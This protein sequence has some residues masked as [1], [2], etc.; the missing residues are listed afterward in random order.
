MS[1]SDAGESELRGGGGESATPL[2]RTARATTDRALQ[3]ERFETFQQGN[4]RGDDNAIGQGGLLSAIRQQETHKALIFGTDRLRQEEEAAHCR[5]EVQIQN[6]SSP[7]FTSC[8]FLTLSKN[9]NLNKAERKLKNLVEPQ[10]AEIG[11]Y[12]SEVSQQAS[13]CHHPLEAASDDPIPKT[14]S[15]PTKKKED[16]IPVI[17]S[18]LGTTR[19]F[20]VNHNFSHGDFGSHGCNG[21]HRIPCGTQPRRN[22]SG[23]VHLENDL[24]NFINLENHKAVKEP[25]SPSVT[26][27]SSTVVT[28]LAPNWSNRLRRTKRFEGS[29]TSDAQG[30]VP[31]V[32]TQ[33][34]GFQELQN[35]HCMER[36]LTDR[37][38]AQQRTP[39][40]CTRSNTVGWSSKSGPASL[41]YESKRK[42]LHTISLDVK[43][44][45]MENKRI[46]ASLVALP[47]SPLSLNNQNE[48]R[49][50]PETGH[51]RGL[52]ASSSKPTT[53][54]ML[55]SLRRFNSNGRISNAGSTFT[56]NEQDK[57]KPLL[58]PSAVSYRTTETGP[59]LSLS[60]SNHRERKISE[61]HFFSPSSINK[62][63]EDTLVARQMQ[64]KSR[65]QASV[66]CSKHSLLSGVPSE[67]QHINTNLFSQCPVP[68][69]RKSP[70]DQSALIKTSALP[71]TTQTPHSWWKQVTLED[72]SPLPPSGT[73][74]RDKSNTP[75]VAPCNDHSDLASPSPTDNTNKTES[76]CK[77]NVNLA[78]KVQGGTHNLTQ[79]NSPEHESDRLVKQ[80]NGSN[81]NR[82]PQ[83]PHSLPSALSSFKIGTTAAQTTLSHPKDLNKH[84]VSNSSFTE[85]VTEPPTLLN[86]K[87]S[88]KPTE[89]SSKLNNN[90]GSS[91]FNSTSTSPHKNNSDRLNKQSFSHANSKAI[92]GLP[93]SPNTK[94]SSSFDSHQV[95]SQTNIKTSSHTCSSSHMPKYTKA[96]NA[97]PIGFERSYASKSFQPKTVSSL[98]P[99]V[100]G[101]SNTNCSPV[102]T[103]SI[104]SFTTCSHPVA[105]TLPN[106]TLHTPLISSTGTSS[107]TTISSLLTPP[108]TPTITSH[109]Y[110]E[111]SSS[112]EAKTFSSTPKTDQRKRLVEGKKMRRV[113]W[114]DSVDLQQSG[115]NTEVR[116]DPSPVPL[117]LLSPSRTPQSVRAT[118]IFS[119]LRSNSPT[120]N[121]SLCSSSPKTSSIQMER[122]G[123][124]RSLSSDS[125]DLKAREWERSNQRLSDNM[126]FDQGRQDFTP[127]Q[128]RTHSVE[129]GT[130]QCQSGSPPSL[131]PDFSSGYKLRYSSP[132]YSSLM[133]S[134]SSKGESKTIMPRS[135]IFQQA[136]QS[137]YAPHL[138]LHIDPTT[139]ITSKPI[140]PQPSSLP[141]QNKT[142]M[143]DR[144]N[145]GVSETDQVNNNQINKNSSQ[146]DQNR[147]ILLVDN[148][149]HISSKSLHDD[150]AFSSSS[151]CV[152]ETLVYSIKSP[153]DTENVT[154][155]PLQH[156]A[157][158][159]VS[160]E[161][162]LSQQVH[163]V[164]RKQETC[165]PHS[166]SNQSSSG[167]SST[168][169]QS[170]DEEGCKSKV[171]PIGKSRFF[172]VESTNEQ[173]P[174]RSRFVLKKSVST[175]NPSLSR[176]DPER[177]NKPN[178][179]MDQVLNRL[180]QTFSNKRSDDDQSFPR[181][182]K[183]AS[184]TPSVSGSSD[185]SSVRDVT[186][187]ST[188]TSE[189]REEDMEIL[190]KDKETEETSKWA[191]NKY[192][193]IPPA[194]VGRKMAGNQFSVQ[195]DK[196]GSNN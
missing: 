90:H 37:L 85:N 185:I 105:T 189:E 69:T 180:R 108:S 176:S 59:I 158:V 1:T 138:A 6:P 36:V 55:L 68:L 13:P 72:T 41:D 102:S 191:Q 171:K 56:N 28:V 140:P 114:E 63:I 129:L 52:L 175:P 35:R 139:V 184:Q 29:S 10:R 61:K 9:Q 123:K 21:L 119:F 65:T 113:T 110:S 104:T 125:A 92:S 43:S 165:K 19:D 161:T 93:L 42:M 111:T 12:S 143:Q 96:A 179:K 181:K 162:S 91:R 84:D 188:R 16:V 134:R 5:D 136:S 62:D 124:F 117:N 148:R 60:S 3:D 54:S 160:M 146:N 169:S 26:M 166:R 73:N 121:T 103:V 155:K 79:R 122:G 112:K 64:T 2:N 126:I 118:S 48:Q 32:T 115:A 193:I 190:L 100:S 81:L 192:T 27:L 156:S 133:S 144:S 152:T 51:Q 130:P 186:V 182:W 22:S 31:D 8:F 7:R 97:T 14:V 116:S 159:P 157:S 177:S 120:K 187:E 173:S 174:K 33:Q 127:R 128:E 49:R 147:K 75:R 99:T 15:L 150:E 149:V 58:S 87:S 23:S 135:P 80:Q 106:P 95:S 71:R 39:S 11:D 47:L 151:T 153:V 145:G 101:S 168:D 194:A 74:I 196:L 77:G 86:P 178:N 142:A 38:Q 70:Y 17:C 94:A 170:W 76:V 57:L 53:S 167:S 154:P 195:L 4:P 20:S 107:P 30:N 88:N 40:L 109:S 34:E 141:L 44:E 183:R 67:R 98:I 131:P 137:V 24:R 89:S 164:H 78:I 132:P 50:T 46:A 83:E 45:R 172:S 25:S 82:K 18:E 66:T 163:T